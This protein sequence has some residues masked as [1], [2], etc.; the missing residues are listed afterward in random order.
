MNRKKIVIHQPDFMPY[1]GFFDRFRDADL[2]VALDNVQYVNSSRGWTNRDKI[3]TEEGEKWLS[4]SV[5]KT[6]R[7]TLIK[8][9]VISKNIDWKKKHLSIIHQNYGSSPYY[10]EIITNIEKIYQIQYENLRDFNM[11]LIIYFMETLNLKVPWIWSSDLNISGSKNELL[12]NI[13][14][15]LNGTHYISGVGAKNY[16]N[17]ESFKESGIEVIWQKFNHPIY[18]QNYS[19]FIPNLSVL[20]LLLNCGIEQSQKIMEA[21]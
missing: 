4:V 9:V 17:E 18:K 3:K 2:Y 6:S 12:I 20:D 14:K 8:D 10:E 13:I 16:L 1:L 7:S 5:E 19:N 11:H 15:K 21:V